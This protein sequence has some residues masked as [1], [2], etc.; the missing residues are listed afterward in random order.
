MRFGKVKRPDL[1]IVDEAQ[2]L[3]RT[4]GGHRR[5]TAWRQHS[6]E[7]PQGGG[8]IEPVERRG[9]HHGIQGGVVER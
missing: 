8:L 1:I 9:G 5:E 3:P 2:P 4:Q 6:V 7:L